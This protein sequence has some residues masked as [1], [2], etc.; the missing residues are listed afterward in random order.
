MNEIKDLYKM[1]NNTNIKYTIKKVIIYKYIYKLYLETDNKFDFL[2]DFITKMKNKTNDYN[3][4]NSNLRLIYKIFKL[5]K[6]ELKKLRKELFKLKP[7]SEQNYIKEKN[8]I[9]NKM[10]LAL[11][12]DIE[13]KNYYKLQRERK[14]KKIGYNNYLAILRNRYHKWY[15]SLSPLKK[16]TLKNNRNLKYKNMEFE[17]KQKLLM[18]HRLYYKNKI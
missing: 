17:T 18:R 11:L 1:I 16:L 3:E 9:R 7:I 5:D 2:L 4:Y 8:N 6:I 15:H 12:T 10:R 14:I 13:R